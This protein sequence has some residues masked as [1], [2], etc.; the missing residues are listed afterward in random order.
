MDATHVLVRHGDWQRRTAVRDGESWAGAA[1]RVA[2]ES[3]LPGD[4]V[5]T[6]LAGP[7]KQ[8]G[9]D[10]S[11]RVT[12]RPM[13]HGDL[14][15]LRRWLLAEHVR[16]WWPH[17][18][19]TAD[20][21]AARYGPRLDGHEPTRMWVVE[22]NGRSVGFVQDYL[23]ADHPAYALLTPDP[24]A[25]GVDFAIGERAWL[26]R[27]I[28]TRMLWAWLVGPL[29]RGYPRAG[30][31]FSSPDHRNAASLRALQKVGFTPGAWFDE[32]QQD[33]SVHTLVGCTLD[34]RRVVG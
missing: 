33:G 21:V 30:S 24:Q 13:V 6:D 26:G 7:E 8:F 25:V 17:Q 27:G 15:H 31:A 12:L 2:Q 20:A 14:G 22:A 4:P 28:G 5:P 34:I 1:T 9:I 29:L 11:L 18:E 23:V 16:R 3:G 32:P 19:L 10:R